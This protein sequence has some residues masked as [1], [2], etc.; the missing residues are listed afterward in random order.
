MAYLIPDQFESPYGLIQEGMVSKHNIASSRS[1]VGIGS[2]K[3]KICDLLFALWQAGSCTVTH[4]K[5]YRLSVMPAAISLPKAEVR[6]SIRPRMRML[7]H[8]SL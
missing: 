5:C 7:P 2:E 3:D 8:I 1:E 4:T 6:L